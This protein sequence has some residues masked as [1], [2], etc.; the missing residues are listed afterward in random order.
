MPQAKQNVK[1]DTILR[2]CTSS[3][4]SRI[5]HEMDEMG[6]Q[7]SVKNVLSLPRMDNKEQGMWNL[8]LEKYSI[9]LIPA[10]LSPCK[11]FPTMNPK[12]FCN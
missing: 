12:V 6:G 8:I 9:Y 5:V 1:M 4:F 10:L 3:L 2:Q 11:I 7:I